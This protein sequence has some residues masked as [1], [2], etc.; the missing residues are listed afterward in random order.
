M[1]HA[2]TEEE[3]LYGF[4]EGGGCYETKE[5]YLDV[6]YGIDSY[7]YR[8]EYISKACIYKKRGKNYFQPVGHNIP[9]IE[10]QNNRIEYQDSV[11]TLHVEKYYDRIYVEF[12]AP[13]A[14]NVADN[15]VGYY[16]ESPDYMKVY[17]TKSFLYWAKWTPTINQKIQAA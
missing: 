14:Y 2:A 7:K 10:F 6:D 12:T 4:Y 13:Y 11:V 3:W 5:N 1:T 8:A 15:Y 9:P 16:K 17:K